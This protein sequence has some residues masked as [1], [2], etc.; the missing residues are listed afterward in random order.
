MM[1]KFKKYCF[2]LNV[3]RFIVYSHVFIYTIYSI[4]DKLFVTH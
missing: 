3:D 2:I 4:F 1:S